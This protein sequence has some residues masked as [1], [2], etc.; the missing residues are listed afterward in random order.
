MI[1]FFSVYCRIILKVT[2]QYILGDSTR[3]DVQSKQVT[4]LEIFPVQ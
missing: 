3:L 4:S 2:S 1:F